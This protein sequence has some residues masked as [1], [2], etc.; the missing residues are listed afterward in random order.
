MLQVELGFVEWFVKK[1]RYWLNRPG[2]LAKA[3]QAGAEWRQDQNAIDHANT[4]YR[5][6]G[7]PADPV[8]TEE[9]LG[10]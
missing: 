7:M 9:E 6:A 10:I 3:F 1:G 4:F 2:G 5:T 8:T